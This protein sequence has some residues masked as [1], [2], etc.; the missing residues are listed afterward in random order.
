MT[1]ALRPS[2]LFVVAFIATFRKQSPTGSD[3][4]G[5]DDPLADRVAHKFRA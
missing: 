1:G 2:S 3:F 5:F 4:S